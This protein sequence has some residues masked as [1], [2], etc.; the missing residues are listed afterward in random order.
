MANSGN[1][2]ETFF[3]NQL[4]VINTINIAKKADFLVNEKYTFELEDKSKNQKQIK[5]VDNA[6]IVK[7][8]IETGI[9]N[10]IPLW[11]FGFLY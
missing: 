6:F 2:K 10:I 9:D 5:N 1:L 4:S 3:V 8:D 7:D 11:L